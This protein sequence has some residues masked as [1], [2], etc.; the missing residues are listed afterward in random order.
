MYTTCHAI[1]PGMISGNHGSIQP[2]EHADI[3]NNSLHS[4]RQQG[5][6]RNNSP[7]YQPTSPSS[8]CSPSTCS[9]STCSTSEP[10]DLF[11]D[12]APTDHNHHQTISKTFRKSVPIVKSFIFD[13]EPEQWLDWIGLFNATINSTDMTNSEKMTHLQKFVS[14]D[15]KS[16]IRGYGCNGAMYDAALQ[17]LEH[18]FGNPTKIVTSFLRRLDA[19][20]GPNLRHTRSYKDLANFL[21]TMVDTFTTLGFQHD[22][23]STTNVQTVL[24]KLPTP[25]RLEWNR[26]NL[27]CNIRQPSLIDLTNW[28]NSYAEACSD[29]PSNSNNNNTRNSSSSNN[30]NS[31]N[32]QGLSSNGHTHQHGPSDHRANQNN[33]N[34]QR[35]QQQ[36]KS[37][38]KDQRRDFLPGETQLPVPWKMRT[39]HRNEPKGQITACQGPTT[40]FQLPQPPQ[41][42]R[43]SI[44]AN[45]PDGRMQ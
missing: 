6:N 23:H 3:I 10:A 24:S 33:R 4:C 34:Q 8:T 35:S 11:S 40:M 30:Y 36:H 13:G 2:Y 38:Q 20:S 41:V 5:T 31:S 43:L 15:A 37:G 25:C 29:L 45:L 27:Q 14:G 22:L 44:N 21:Q 1:V 17:R 28:F 42:R 26:Y 9:T 16:L 12:S 7:K 18:D 39:L 32:T 19:I